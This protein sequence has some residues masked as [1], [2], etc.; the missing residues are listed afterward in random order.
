MA[1]TPV[2]QIFLGAA[3]ESA[4]YALDTW[5][6]PAGTA[7]RG[8]FSEVDISPDGAAPTSHLLAATSDNTCQN[9]PAQ[10]HVINGSTPQVQQPRFSPDGTRIA[11]IEQR[12]QSDV[13]IATV[14]FDGTDY[15][16]EAGDL[17]LEPIRL[18]YLENL[19]AR[20]YHP[21]PEF[22]I[23]ELVNDAGVVGAA[24]LARLHASQR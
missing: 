11:Y 2:R 15:D 4:D 21:E 5:E 10:V 9:P 13:H 18:A 7:S 16:A 23:A 19:P 8:A 6:G 1:R 17:L 3:A 20:G 12:T 22:R 24:D 14:G